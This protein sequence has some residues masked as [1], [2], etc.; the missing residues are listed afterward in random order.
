[1][2]QEN[3]SNSKLAEKTSSLLIA[4]FVVATAVVLPAAIWVANRLGWQLPAPLQKLAENL[5]LG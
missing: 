3:S 4:A 5:G 2:S 1:M